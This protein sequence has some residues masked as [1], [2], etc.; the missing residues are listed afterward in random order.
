MDEIGNLSIEM[1]KRLLTFLENFRYT[2]IGETHEREADIHLILAWNRDLDEAIA[3]G[4]FLKELRPRIAT[5]TLMIPSLKERIE[6]IPIIVEQHLGKPL[7][8]LLDPPKTAWRV[9]QA[10]MI[11]KWESNIRDLLKFADQIAQIPPDHIHKDVAFVSALLE[12]VDRP[13]SPAHARPRVDNGTGR[14]PLDD[15]WQTIAGIVMR[16][17]RVTVGS[18][19]KAALDM[20]RR[21]AQNALSKYAKQGWL[22]GHWFGP[23]TYYTKG[24]AWP[25]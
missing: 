19:R 7:S 1:Q 14:I 13:S 16:D 17:G 23:A 3:K 24:P 2:P 12:T 8:E 18:L 6:D 21:H 11:K 15:E 10:M 5:P 4:E 25:A 20:G 22:L 9:M